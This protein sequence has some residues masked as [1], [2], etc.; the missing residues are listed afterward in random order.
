MTYSDI[1]FSYNQTLSGISSNGSQTTNGST[2]TI[3][4]DY[5]NPV[6]DINMLTGLTALIIGLVALGVVAGIH[7]LGSGLSEYSVKIIH[8]ASVYYGL[9]GVF[10][11]LSITVFTSIPLFGV[12]LWFILTV[13]YTL[14]FFHQVTTVVA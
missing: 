13:V 6:F 11:A 14:G 5:S 2:T 4:Q 12:F 8:A 1:D 7:V 3:T 10:S 9:W